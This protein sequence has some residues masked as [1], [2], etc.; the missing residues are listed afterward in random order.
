MEQTRTGDLVLPQGTYVLLQDG[1][2]GNVNVVVGPHK[3]SLA[4]TDKPVV[5]ER[6]SR[7]YSPATAE[8]A[9]KVWPSAD[10]GQYLVLTNPAA[11]GEPKQHPPKGKQDVFVKLDSGRRVNIQGPVDFALFPG[12]VADVI[13]GHQLK[14]NEYLIIRVYNENEA[15]AN[16]ASAVVKTT[17]ET[18][19]DPDATD[20]QKAK[21]KK[22]AEKAQ[23]KAAQ[24]LFDEKEIRT[25]N[26]L[27]IKGTDVSFYIPPT[28][29][30]VLED[31][32]GNYTRN[33]VTL[34][35]LEYCILLDQNGDK[36]YV[37]GPAVVFPK[38]TESF[39][40]SNKRKVFKAIELNENMGIYIK[41]IADY[42]DGK[43]SYQAGEELFI[44]GREQKIYFPRPEH[45]IIKYDNELIHYATAVPAGEGRYLLD[46][47]TGD[48][49]TVKGPKML[50]PDP[51]KEVIVKRVLDPKQ[52]ALWFPGNLEAAEYN[53]E[54]AGTMD[55]S[56][57]MDF[58][59][60]YSNALYSNQLSRSMGAKSTVLAST[61]AGDMH[62]EM[63]RRSSY[64]KPRTI[65]LDTKYEGAVTLNIW[66]NFAVQVV[67]RAGDR[68]VVNGPK[69]I[70]LDY[71]ETLDVLELSNGKPKN[72]HNLIRTVY[73]QT[74]NNVVS[75][76]VTVETKDLVNLDIRIS[77][78]VNF[79]GKPEQWFNVSDYIK[80]MTQHMR[81][82]VR[83]AVK[84]R[85]VEDF[86][87]NATDIIRDTILGP[88]TKDGKRAG[89]LFDENGMRIYD[90]E[91]LN[92]DIADTKIASM[93]V[94]NQHQIIQQNLQGE[95]M[96]KNMDYS[97]K[98]EK[99]KREQ[100]DETLLTFR[101]QQE[102]ANIEFEEKKKAEEAALLADVE[103]QDK[104]DEIAKKKNL[105]NKEA[106]MVE[107][108]IEKERSDI[109]IKAIKAQMEAISPG[110]IEA[111]TASQGVELTR[112]LAENLTAQREGN[113]LRDL[114]AGGVKGGLEG[115]LSSIAGTPLEAK[116]TSILDN[117]K[118]LSKK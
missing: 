97:K 42:E 1:A 38:P 92:L 110:L 101:K 44:T 112:V 117:Y 13:D 30:E 33:A 103:K 62:E 56:P 60:A 19:L 34:E 21:A 102:A 70:M 35:R 24:S 23:E 31:G 82:V 98:E 28:G 116:L 48:V 67:N 61:V 36:R 15:K 71:D 113:P 52:V 73:L 12:Q 115:I 114:F 55:M 75:D 107:V 9:V 57:D 96:R 32:N 68:K 4:D 90:V 89:R 81:S 10:E 104:L 86:Y 41:V 94:N 58:E 26:L 65:E 8:K 77:Y 40:E 93:I 99:L 14:S 80:L 46:K 95:L 91:V 88:S 79:E 84:K 51:R 7:R 66:P 3:V 2:S 37:K 63:T 64:T 27:I 74:Q 108:Q 78:K 6:E 43:N 50:L 106:Q 100:V 17:V 11:E 53:A 25:G 39:I 54:L 87:E 29:I 20:A 118:D 72:D 5:Y 59:S 109:A 16:I 45:A 105:R 49:K 111:L 22:E 47:N 83:N 69:T 18:T 76:I 85:N